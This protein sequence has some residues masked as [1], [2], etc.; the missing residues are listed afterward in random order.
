[1]KTKIWYGNQYVGA[2]NLD[3]VSLRT[4]IKRFTKKVLKV[5][6]IVCIGM[7]A[8]VGALKAGQHLF[9]KTIAQEVIVEV[10]GHVPVMDRIAKCESGGYHISPKTGQI[11]MRANTNG[12]VDLGKYQINSIWS[13][14]ATELGF[15]L[16][17]ES[18]NEKMAY[19]IYE[20][21]GTGDWYSSEKC[22]SK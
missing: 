8:L 18:D 15:D 19:W 16:T 14:K 2:W 21:K 3:K 9:P 11:V 22:W 7:W 6:A 20:N 1:M 5:G 12:S 10:K 4:R 17:K 13:K